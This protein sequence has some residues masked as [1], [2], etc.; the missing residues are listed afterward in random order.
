MFNNKKGFTFIELLILFTISTI[1][2]TLFGTIAVRTHDTI[3]YKQFTKQFHQDLLY[4]QQLAISER[5]HYFL[6]FERSKNRYHIRRGGNGISVLMRVYP[7]E[8]NVHPHTLKM[9][10]EFSQKGNI[11]RPGTMRIQT[12]FHSFFI[13]CPFGKGRCYDS[14]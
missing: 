4:L 3:Q 2:L 10:I 6:Q 9:P 12:K 7:E 14:A 13:T 11:K 5:E 1:I 8:W